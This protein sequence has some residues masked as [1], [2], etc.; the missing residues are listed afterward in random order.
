MHPLYGALPVPY[1]PVRV[2]HCALLVHRYTYTF[3]RC[4]PLSTSEF[5]FPSQCLCETIVL[6]L[7]SIVWDWPVS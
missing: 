5:L 7:Y 6:T 3:P 1:E 4:R 2:T